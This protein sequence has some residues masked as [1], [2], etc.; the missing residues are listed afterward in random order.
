MEIC[1]IFLVNDLV[2][3]PEE[4]SINLGSPKNAK[5]RAD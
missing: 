2:K 3:T 1:S 4:R 5:H